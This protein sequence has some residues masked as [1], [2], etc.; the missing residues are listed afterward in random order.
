MMEAVLF[1]TE[2]NGVATITL[3]R[4]KA[5]NSLTHDMLAAIREKLQIWEK[6]E[7]VQLVIL[8]GAGTKGL[9]AGGDI[10]ALYEAKENEKKMAEAI[11]F[12]DVEYKTDLLMQQFSKPII[13]SL[14]GIVMGGGVGLSYGCS[15]RVVTQRT[16]WAMPEMNIGFFPDVG[17]AYFLNR[18]PGCIGRYLALN[19]TVLRGADVCHINGA[20]YYMNDENLA[21]LLQEI[22]HINW[23]EENRDNKLHLLFSKYAEEPEIESGKLANLQGDIDR[24]FKHDTV[25]N[26]ISSLEADDSEFAQQTK[27]NMLS[28]SPVSLKVTLTQLIRGE[29]KSFEAC[30]KTDLILAKNFMEH[31]DFYEGVRSVLIDKDQQPA[32][33]YRQLADVTETFVD[34]FFTN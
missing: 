11:A 17:A 4:P 29:E 14:D 6:D 26:I 15:H 3:N 10:K 1:L 13:A 19:A 9:C 30:L 33:Q 22:S 18:A 25:E 23:H 32:Y 27:L 20:D 16:K 12:F 28:K 24:H 34:S 7:N 31:D 5:I 2:S 21:A 8:K